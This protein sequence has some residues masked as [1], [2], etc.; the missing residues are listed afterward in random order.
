MSWV[1][2]NCYRADEF[3]ELKVNGEKRE[4]NVDFEVICD[5]L[6]HPG[7][8]F[9]QPSTEIANLR[10]HILK[11]EECQGWGD[12]V[13]LSLEDMEPEWQAAIL[14]A[15]EVYALENLEE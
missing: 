3:F 1:R 8:H 10:K 6:N 12:L 5:E 11:I 13:R 15:V 9:E 4:F 2:K 14:E 7:N